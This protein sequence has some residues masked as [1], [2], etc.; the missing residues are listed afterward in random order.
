MKTTLITATDFLNS[1]LNSKLEYRFGQLEYDFS[2]K[3]IAETFRDE[4]RTW[5]TTVFFTKN[6][7]NQKVGFLKTKKQVVDFI[8]KHSKNSI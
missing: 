7:G 2:D 4:K 1:R 3:C 8:N 5:T 6:K